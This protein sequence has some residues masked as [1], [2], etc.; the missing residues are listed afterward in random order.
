MSFPKS[1]WGRLL[2]YSRLGT[3]EGWRITVFESKLPRKTWKVQAHLCVL[4]TLTDFFPVVLVRATSF[5]ALM[6]RITF[7]V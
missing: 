4:C 3:S 7:S 1:I 2:Y 6:N 5:S